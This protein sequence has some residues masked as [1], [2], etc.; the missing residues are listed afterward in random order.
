MWQYIAM[1][2]GIALLMV[3]FITYNTLV[4]LNNKVKEAFSVMDVFLKKRWDLIPNLV[5][6]VKGYA[7]HE[8]DTLEEIVNLRNGVYDDMS[9]DEKI[10]TNEQIS[11]TITKLMALAEAYPELKASENFK[12]LSDKLTKI[13]EDIADT[14]KRYNGMVRIFNDR[15]EMFP[16]NVV[17][18]IFGFKTKKMFEILKPE[19]ENIK[20]EL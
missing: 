6:T 4:K 2:I 1:G 3:L 12:D 15:V 17:A 5:E 19:K 9:N 13:E 8:K 7:K 10:K 11:N 16:S 18:K 14:R 20:I